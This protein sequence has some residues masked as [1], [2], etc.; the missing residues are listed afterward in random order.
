MASGGVRIPWV[1]RV[2][3]GRLGW[4]GAVC[5]W[6]QQVSGN[7]FCSSLGHRA[8]QEA[9]PGLQEASD[10]GSFQWAYTYLIPLW[11]SRLKLGGEGLLNHGPFSIFSISL[12]KVFGAKIQFSLEDPSA[13]FWFLTQWILLFKLHLKMT[14]NDNHWNYCYSFQNNSGWIMSLKLAF[15]KE[16]LWSGNC[17]NFFNIISNIIR[18]K[19]K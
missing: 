7:L 8:I 13:E 5:W 15:T 18:A 16:V 3:W 1:S 14:Y 19:R 2:R 4:G 9:Q 17:A 12:V 10:A 6:S 11:R